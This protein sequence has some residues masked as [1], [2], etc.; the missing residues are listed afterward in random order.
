M[1]DRVA[2]TIADWGIRDGYFVDDEEAQAFRDE[3]KYVLVH[4]R[5]A[6]NSP[7][8][9]NIGVKGVPQQASACQPYDALVATPEGLVPIGRLVEERAIGTKVLDANGLTSVVA[10]KHNGRKQ[11]LRVH[12]KAGITL[13]VTGDHRRLAAPHRRGC[14][15]G[16]CRRPASRRPARMAPQS[17][18]GGPARSRRERSPR[19]RSRVGCSP[20]DLSASTKPERTD[21]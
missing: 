20:T 17:S 11:V 12:T 1:I 19:R 6:F 5:A 16:D 4:Q 10:V 2:D 13:D 14:G 21:R 18:R 9:F 3:L 15:L 8:W 7:V